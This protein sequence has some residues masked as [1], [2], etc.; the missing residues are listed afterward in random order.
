[1]RIIPQNQ[2]DRDLDIEELLKGL[3]AKKLHLALKNILGESVRLLDTKGKLIFGSDKTDNNNPRIALSIQIEPVAY[4]EAED[5]TKIRSVALLLE[6]LLKSSERYN[7]ASDLHL[8]SVHAD[9]E[10][11]QKK[12]EALLASES[13]YK[14]LAENLEQRVQ[15]QVK[16]IDSAQRQLYQTEKLASVGQLAAGVAH[17]INNPVGFIRSNLSTASDYVKNITEFAQQFNVGMDIEAL[18]ADWQQKD[19][20]FI[21]ED[22]SILLNE[23]IDGADR[24]KTIVADLKDFS[25]VD[26]TEVSIA[27]INKIIQSVGNVAKSQVNQKAEIEFDLKALPKTQCSS[28]KLGQVFLNM[29]QNATHAIKHDHGKIKIS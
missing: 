18:K 2:F 16:T 3:N 20:D 19:L 8:E 25:N 13:K 22:F 17:E 27:D 28:G 24:V 29:I 11:L 4:L 10:K 9:Y 15:E 7:M 12:H 21:L 6:Q 5:D 23:S 26:G 14:E 1:M